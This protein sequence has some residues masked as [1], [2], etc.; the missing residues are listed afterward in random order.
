MHTY[1]TD[2]DFRV[3]LL[4]LLG[5]AAYVIVYIL[6]VYLFPFLNRLIPVEIPELL[7]I[8]LA[9]G[10]VFSGVYMLFATRLWNRSWMPSFAVAVPDLT[11]HWEGQIQTSFEG[12]IDEEYL[13]AD[14]GDSEGSSERYR[15]MDATLDIQQTWRKI[16]ITFETGRSSSYSTGA[17]FQMERTLQPRLSYLFQNEGPSPD[18]QSE[19]EGRYTGAAEFQLRQGNGET[20]LE[21]VYYTGPAR[22]HSEGPSEETKTN[23]GS[24][25]FTRVS[26]EPQL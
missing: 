13:A 2:N 14:G 6:N 8:G 25:E 10:V 7:F 20:V 17:S 15:E 24:A 26:G 3:T 12:E 11:G 9:Y 23:Y 18:E 19:S 1:S 16:A 22:E 21:G 5:V 4:G